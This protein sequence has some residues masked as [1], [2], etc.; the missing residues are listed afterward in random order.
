MDN[1]DES[2]MD[3]EKVPEKIVVSTKVYKL[4]K[5]MIEMNSKVVDSN[6]NS[7]LKHCQPRP[8]KKETKVKKPKTPWSFGNSIWAS[9]WEYEYKGDTSVSI[10]F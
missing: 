8:T 5:L 10:F 6:Y 2:H 7:L 4:G 9:I 3:M 1:L